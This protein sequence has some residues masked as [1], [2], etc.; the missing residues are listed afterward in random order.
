MVLSISGSDRWRDPTESPKY[1]RSQILEWY[2]A[3]KA[4]DPLNRMLIPKY[5]MNDG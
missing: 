3:I 4:C 5:G 1:G 2:F